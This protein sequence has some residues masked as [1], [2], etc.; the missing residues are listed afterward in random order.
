MGEWTTLSVRENTQERFNELKEQATDDNGP[1]VSADAFL[2]SLLDTWDAVDDEHYQDEARA[3]IIE[4]IR[5]QL[6]GFDTEQT[7]LNGE[8]AIINRIDDLEA[9]LKT[10]MEGLRR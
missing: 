4:D 3:E 1:P 8:K 2:G 7:D 6:D 9:E 5:E 10:H